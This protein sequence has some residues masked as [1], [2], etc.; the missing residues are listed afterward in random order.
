MVPLSINTESPQ[1]WGIWNYSW[2]KVPQ[3][4]HRGFP[5]SFSQT[6][7]VKIDLDGRGLWEL[8]AT[9]EGR[10]VRPLDRNFRQSA[11]LKQ[12]PCIVI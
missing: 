7:S 2:S 5:S 12:D 8:R 3:Q 4:R 6:C 1:A 10:D 9:V 11:G